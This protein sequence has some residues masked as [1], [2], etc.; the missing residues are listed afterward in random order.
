MVLVAL[1]HAD[2]PGHER[3]QP[4]RV[5]RQ[6]AADAV[7]FQVR[8]VDQV[9]PVTVTELVPLGVVGVVTGADGV[10]VVAL[11]QLDVLHHPFG[12]HVLPGVRIELVPIDAV[13]ADRL[14]VQQEAAVPDL[15]LAEADARALGFNQSAAG[16][17]ERQ[18]ERVEVRS[19]RRPLPGGGD[20]RFEE[21]PAPGVGLAQD[22]IRT[23]AQRFLEHRPPVGVEQL[24]FDGPA[25]RAAA[26][27]DSKPRADLQRG[28]PVL[29][30][31]IRA[32]AEIDD[33]DGGRRE[34]V[35]VTVDAAQAPG[36]LVL[37]VAGIRP[38]E[39]L[40]GEE[41][42]PVPQVRRDVELGGRHAV[43]AV[44]D[45]LPVDPEVERAVDAV[46]VQDH[47]PAP[48]P[49]R[50]VERGAIRPHGVVARRNDRRLRIRG[51]PG[52]RDVQV[53]RLVV[54]VNLPV[55]RHRD[56]L[57]SAVVEVR[58]E[59]VARA[60]RRLLDVEEA[61]RA[62]QREVEGGTLA[63]AG[64]RLF[65][66]CIRHQRRVSRQ[67]VA[68]DDGWV[69]PLLGRIVGAAGERAHR[70]EQARERDGQRQPPALHM[71]RC[72]LSAHLS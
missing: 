64:E 60:V 58:A 41:V 31:E 37:E 67:L 17:F 26:V 42:L 61:P 4:E 14:A 62:V 23:D 54:A 29:V 21:R 27:E 38:P 33:V 35:D 16:V 2:S 70:H 59:E 57:P 52:V 28:V 44:A 43:L 63:R 50:H 32:H 18:H 19:L 10:D 34:Q 30:V 7:R 47:P 13:K 20:L 1:D 49:R 55:R 12:R 48:P 71:S 11:H 72:V 66:G 46:E 9:D 39:D 68:G 22:D 25:F 8:L 53:D 51:R 69:L 5:V 40:C 36:V 3:R 45:R 56:R 65:D 15:D 6:A 24:G